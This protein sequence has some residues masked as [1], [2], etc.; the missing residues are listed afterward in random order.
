VDITP[1]FGNIPV[2]TGKTPE[3]QLPSAA[4]QTTDFMKLLLAQLKSQDP[5]GAMDDKDMM[6]QFAQLTTVQELQKLTLE[7]Q[8]LSN[9]NSMSYAASLIGKEV[10]AK[11]GGQT[12][13]GLVDSVDVDGGNYT[14]LVGEKRVPLSAVTIVRAR[15]ED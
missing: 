14:L 3:S 1:T 7:I 12:V 13:E 2:Y 5:M 4:Q 9:S 8:K 10:V 6:M 15:Q 11:W